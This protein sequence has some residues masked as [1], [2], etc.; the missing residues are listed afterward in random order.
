MCIRD[1]Y[2]GRYS[3][4]SGMSDSKKY[5]AKATATKNVEIDGIKPL[6]ESRFFVE[7]NL[8]DKYT[9]LLYTSRCV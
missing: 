9:C 6:P 2:D 8:W 1:R 4:F 5:A 3:T 7:R